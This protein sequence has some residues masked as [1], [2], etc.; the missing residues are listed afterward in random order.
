MGK[1]YEEQWFTKY[2]AKEGI[3]HE[4]TVSY[5]PQQNGV[6]ER[7]NR[8]LMEAEKSIMFNNPESTLKKQKKSLLELMGPFL[9]ASIYVRTRSMT[10]T[11]DATPTKNIST[12]FQKSTI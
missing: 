3:L 9:L 7:A 11:E 12:K 4:T 10:N 6:A 5:T 2:L 8:T 1:E